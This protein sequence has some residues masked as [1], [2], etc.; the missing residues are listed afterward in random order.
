MEAE[1]GVRPFANVEASRRNMLITKAKCVDMRG[2][3]F[4]GDS[5]TGTGI[6]VDAYPCSNQT[7]DRISCSPQSRIDS[8]VKSVFINSYSTRAH[9]DP[10]DHENPIKHD[11]I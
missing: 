3:V 1:T 10:N 5:L 11:I 9:F 2:V 6:V 7:A 8:V 4:S